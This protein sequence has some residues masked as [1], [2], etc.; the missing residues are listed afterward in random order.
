[1]IVWP[2]PIP[3]TDEPWT[4]PV[5]NTEIVEVSDDVAMCPECYWTPPPD[6]WYD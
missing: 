2:E 4:C 1:M 5:C 6:D 3:D